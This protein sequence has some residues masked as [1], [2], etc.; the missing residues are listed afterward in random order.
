MYMKYLEV[1]VDRNVIWRR[2]SSIKNVMKSNN[3]SGAWKYVPNKAH[4]SIKSV[5]LTFTMAVE[6]GVNKM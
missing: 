4:I 5:L 1:I 6:S 2:T 3:V